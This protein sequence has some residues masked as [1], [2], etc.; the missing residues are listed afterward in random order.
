MG[1]D[2]L[3][4]KEQVDTTIEALKTRGIAGECLETKEEAL[5]RLQVLIPAG[6]RHSV[7]NRGDGMAR[8]FY[9]YRT[10]QA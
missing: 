2:T 8:W 7:F 6:A 9:G 5:A 1:F 10:T 4:T 3:A